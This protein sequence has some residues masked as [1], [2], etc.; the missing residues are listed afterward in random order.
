MPDQVEGYKL[1]PQ[2]KDFAKKYKQINN[3]K[4]VLAVGIQYKATEL[5]R[6]QL[7]ANGVDMQINEMLQ[8][9]PTTLRQTTEQPSEDALVINY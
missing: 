7:M 9:A 8:N 3:I 4:K 6:L 1:S 2:Q 5:K